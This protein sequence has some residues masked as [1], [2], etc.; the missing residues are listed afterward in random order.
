M[1][2]G[3]AV[4]A[5]DFDQLTALLSAPLLDGVDQ[6]SSEAKALGLLGHNQGGNATDRRRPMDRDHSVDADEPDHFLAERSD[7]RRLAG[8]LE[9]RQILADL[10]LGD[11]MAEFV[12]QLG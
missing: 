7:D 2:R 4:V 12:N 10:F 8:L 1:R 3:A 6:H 11:F 5:G 9:C